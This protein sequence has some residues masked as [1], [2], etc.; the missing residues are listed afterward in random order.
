MDALDA[1][2]AFASLAT[3]V[4]AILVASNYSPKTMVAG[5]AIFIAASLAWIAVGWL[6]SEQSLLWQNIVLLIV[7]LVG[8]V[9]WLPRTEKSEAF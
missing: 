3:I 6:D 1:L 9:R 5:F 2:K 7:N 4:A 8:V